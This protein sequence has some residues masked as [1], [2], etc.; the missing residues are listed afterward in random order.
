MREPHG[1]GKLNGRVTWK[2]LGAVCAVLAAVIGIASTGIAIGGM[3]ASV[4]ANTSNVADLQGDVRTI[5]AVLLR[6]AVN[7][8]IDV[9]DLEPLIGAKP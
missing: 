9:S 1:G 3:Q 6:L 5:K 4:A 2:Q 8:G 7:E